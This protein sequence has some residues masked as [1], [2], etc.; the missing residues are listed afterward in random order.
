MTTHATIRWPRR[1]CHVLRVIELH[2]EALFE[3]IRKW[4]ARRVIA[5]H[6]LVTDRAH[7][8]IRRGELRKVTAGT[9]FVSRETRS[10]GIVGP[11]MTVV[12]GER[13]VL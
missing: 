11:A 4:L 5:V 3:L 13:S 1:A 9:G 6:V 2:V 10:C 7:R 8:N 12:A